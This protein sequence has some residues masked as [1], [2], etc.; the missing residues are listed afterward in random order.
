[1]EL[2]LLNS[3]SD[4]FSP[5]HRSY[6]KKS[7]QRLNCR[8]FARQWTEKNVLKG[9]PK[10][11]IFSSFLSEFLLART[12]GRSQ[13]HS[14]GWARVPLSSFFPQISIIFS[15][16]FTHCLPHFGPPGGRV[17]HPGRPWLRHC[18]DTKY[19][20]CHCRNFYSIL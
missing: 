6:S 12:Q 14:P 20:H 5:N 9:A 11:I 19:H 2:S 3:F 16:N 10:F 8:L 1:M 15:S 4:H 7:Y 18:T 17:A 13:P